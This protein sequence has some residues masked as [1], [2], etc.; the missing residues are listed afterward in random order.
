MMGN[1]GGEPG[2]GS[3]YNK[4]YGD[5]TQEQLNKLDKLDQD[6]YNETVELR[7]EIRMKSVELNTL[8]N[9]PIPDPIKAKALQNEISSLQAKLDEKRIDYELAVHKTLPENRLSRGYG[10]WHRR[11][12]GG[13][14]RG[15]GQGPGQLRLPPAA[16]QHPGPCPEPVGRRPA[17][18]IR[19]V[20]VNHCAHSA[21]RFYDRDRF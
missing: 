21:C 17:F 20:H 8:L 6:F 14:G 18:E 2:Y 5:L 19:H 1:W 11:H 16:Q 4:E 12:M 13:Y 7:N 3:Q 10:N 9:N 15:V